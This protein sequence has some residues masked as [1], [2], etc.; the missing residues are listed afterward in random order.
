MMLSVSAWLRPSRLLTLRQGP[1][2][3]VRTCATTVRLI[4]ARDYRKRRMVS[5]I[6]AALQT[7]RDT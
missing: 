3:P 2:Q 4:Q 5:L 7:R 6:P 1:E